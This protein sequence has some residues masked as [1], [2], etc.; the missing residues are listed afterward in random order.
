MFLKSTPKLLLSF[1]ILLILSTTCFS[2]QINV[3]NKDSK[4]GL[5]GVFIYN[6]SKSITAITDSLGNVDISDVDFNLLTNEKDV[7]KQ[8]ALFNSVVEKSAKANKPHILCRYLLDLAQSF[9]SYYQNNNILKQED[10][11]KKARL[12]V[13]KSVS[14]VL[15]NGLFLLGIK[16]PVEM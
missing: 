2:Q 12:L 6:M 11:L 1:F 7:V 9:N 4:N 15:Q 14:Q 13:A 16:A 8:I 10:D 3:L 5:N